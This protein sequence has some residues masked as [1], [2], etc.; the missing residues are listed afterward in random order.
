MYTKIEDHPYIAVNA[1]FAVIVLLVLIYSSVFDRLP[2]SYRI[3]SQC[4]SQVFED[5]K[6][7]GLSRGFNLITKLEFQKAKQMNP[8]SMRLFLFFFIQFILR[9]VFSAVYLKYK[10]VFVIDSI[11]SG[12]LFLYSFWVMI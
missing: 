4:K 7:L 11:L 6:S 5:C 2:E 9:F 1:I 12:L 10:R 3:K 8:Y